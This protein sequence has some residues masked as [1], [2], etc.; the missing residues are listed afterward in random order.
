ME[1]AGLG[2]RWFR[3]EEMELLSVINLG[4][5]K[6]DMMLAMLLHKKNGH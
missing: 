3:W 1:E 6:I 2:S 4:T 5:E